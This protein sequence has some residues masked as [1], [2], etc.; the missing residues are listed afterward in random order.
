MKLFLPSARKLIPFI[1]A[2][3]AITACEQETTF[4]EATNPDDKHYEGTW[5]GNTSQTKL[6]SFDVVNSSAGPV[7]SSCLLGYLYNANYKQRKLISLSGLS[8]ISNGN[9][10]FVLPDGGTFMAN[11]TSPRECVGSFEIVDDN[12]GIIKHSFEAAS[13]TSQIS[14]LSTA[15]ISFFLDKTDYTYEQDYNIYFPAANNINTDT[16]II[17]VSGFN[18]KYGS[19][20][21]GLPLFEIR[22][23]HIESSA[24][25]PLL[26]SPGIKNL[27]KDA[28]D[29]F[30]IIYYDPAESNYLYSTS[31]CSGTQDWSKLEIIDFAEIET[32]D[33]DYKLYKFVAQFHCKAC[34]NRR[35]DKYI[36]KGLYI[37]Y[38]HTRL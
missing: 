15:R 5:I 36:A 31:A 4:P 35:P 7:I 3:F 12:G 37:G 21:N 38:I 28:D 1:I 9:F 17:A 13:N 16:G 24:D 10:S 2:F 20:T 30:E 29:G 8:E 32:F 14:L 22:A 18:R 26:F 23:G 34:K 19:L 25:I 6:I 27:S 33:P 11:F